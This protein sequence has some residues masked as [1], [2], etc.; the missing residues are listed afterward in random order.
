LHIQKS[1]KPRVLWGTICLKIQ[2]FAKK[3]RILPGSLEK[4]RDPQRASQAKPQG[5]PMFSGGFLR[6]C[7]KNI[8]G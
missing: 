1:S 4:P 7:F 8:H 3:A 6:L 5:S 2:R